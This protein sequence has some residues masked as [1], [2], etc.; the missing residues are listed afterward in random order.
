MGVSGSWGTKAA[1]AAAMRAARGGHGCM[2]RVFRLSSTRYPPTP[3]SPPP[4]LSCVSLPQ[5]AAVVI[6]IIKGH[7]LRRACLQPATKT[8]NSKPRP[9]TSDFYRAN[10]SNFN[11]L[12]YYINYLEAWKTAR[13]SP[14][15][16]P[17]SL[18]FL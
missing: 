10:I 16:M 3:S 2:G 14:G 17:T 13:N 6:I 4:W 8:Q 7:S 11:C 18:N 5:A 15:L 1:V 12:K 9:P